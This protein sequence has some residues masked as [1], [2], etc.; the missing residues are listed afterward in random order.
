MKDF[1]I[2]NILE[3]KALISKTSLKILMDSVPGAEQWLKNHCYIREIQAPQPKYAA[4]TVRKNNFDEYW[5]DLDP[6][7]PASVPSRGICLGKTNEAALRN[8]F[9]AVIA[10]Q[11]RDK[12]KPARARLDV[13]DMATFW[14]IKARGVVIARVNKGNEERDAAL[15]E[16]GWANG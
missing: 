3:P 5:I 7:T 4:A 9:D 15:A 12:A 14:Q 6:E 1:E 8:L 13:E 11:E 10:G 16:I 2:L